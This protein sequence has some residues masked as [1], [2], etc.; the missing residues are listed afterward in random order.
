MLY[1]IC[2]SWIIL[3]EVLA[4]AQFLELGETKKVEIS[5]KLDNEHAGSVCVTS[6]TREGGGNTV[7]ASCKIEIS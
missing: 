3:R 6:R 2:F 1:E 5:Y 4:E 7:L